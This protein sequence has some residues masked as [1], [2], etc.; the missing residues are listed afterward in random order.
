[1]NFSVAV[2]DIIEKYLTSNAIDFVS[3]TGKTTNREKII[4]RFNE[5]PTC[6]VFVGS[7]KAGGVGIDL[8]AGSVVIHYIAG[9]TLQRKTRQRIA[10]TASAR[11]GVCRSSPVRKEMDVIEESDH[12]YAQMNPST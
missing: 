6:R 7:L 4:Q 10:C 8:V 2:F 11:K 3:L 5:D 9:G 1:M 12:R